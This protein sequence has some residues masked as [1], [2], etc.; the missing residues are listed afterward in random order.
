MIH[1]ERGGVALKR[2]HL[3]VPIAIGPD[4][5]LPTEVRLFHRG[6]NTTGKGDFLYDEKAAKLVME[7]FRGHDVLAMIDL[8]HLSVA[9]GE[10]TGDARNF[11]PDARGW[12]KIEDRSVECWLHA[13][14]WTADG[15]ERLLSK[16]QRYLS[17]AIDTD[18]DNR[19]VRIHNIAL[20]AMPATDSAPS[21]VASQRGQKKMNPKLLALLSGLRARFGRVKVLADGAEGKTSGGIKDA[22]AA[23]IEA[24]TAAD[25]AVGGG[26]MDAAIEAIKAAQEAV[27]AFET[28]AASVGAKDNAA[29][30]ADAEP[31]GAAPSDAMMRDLTKEVT[32]L[33]K[34]N[35]EG[36]RELET[37]RTERQARELEERRVLVATLVKLGCEK[38]HTAWEK[39]DGKTPKGSLLSMP[40]EELREKVKDL[41]GMPAAETM[42]H[43]RPREGTSVAMPSDRLVEISEYEQ[44]RLRAVADREYKL[45][46]RTDKPDY[47]LS[48]VKYIDVKERQVRGASDHTTRRRLSRALNETD[49]VTDVRGLR[50]APGFTQLLTSTPVQPIQEFGQASQRFLE[51]W[52]LEFIASLVSQPES[53]A[54]SIGVM[55]GGQTLK[56]TYPVSF[57]VVR[58]MEKSASNAAAGQPQSGETTI[59]KREFRAA[60]Q[61][62]LRRI[63][64]GDFAYVRSW[65]EAAAQMARARVFLRNELVTT[66]LEGGTD[67]SKTGYWL[68]TVER[69]TGVDGQPFFSASHKVNPFDKTK[70]KLGGGA[71]W[72][73]YQSAA[74]PLGTPSTA[75]GYLTDEKVNL[76][77]VPGLDG[78][79]IGGD[80]D[81]M[82]GPQILKESMRLLLTVQDLILAAD[83]QT[84]AT[85]KFGTIKNEHFMSG[86]T[87]IAGPELAGA[88][89]TTADWYL[90]SM[91]RIKRGMPPWVISENSAEELIVWDE[92]S[93]FYKST[94]L[95]K[96]ESV[97]MTNV[98]FLYPHGIRLIKGS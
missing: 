89:K 65:N 42:G 18:E 51:E 16:K 1:S 68:Q 39:S 69:A 80:A 24:L 47:E 90:L 63:A 94:G 72:G 91:E 20:T 45:L 8:E 95:V 62:E 70:T 32:L 93:D 28:A 38:P 50:F 82:L 57:D 60:K 14:E 92:S 48:L 49:V 76:S 6:I 96:I 66:L 98:G 83:V 2:V 54:E 29:A 17:P 9:P 10:V 79:L 3:S 33:R 15:A 86:L 31:A 58:Y 37:L 73:N 21:L 19:V 85:G 25:K 84:S 5:K 59:N 67:T 22:I 52:R 74:E 34:S 61:A 53:W 71:T 87:Y 44:Q 26:D 78:K 30:E 46:H 81:T 4:G 56:D 27:D 36:R 55:L 88:A 77:M 64:Y 43:V 13:I 23:A 97:V 7:E 75:V 11:D 40:I 35:E 41:G 12:A